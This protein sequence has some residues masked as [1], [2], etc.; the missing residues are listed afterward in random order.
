MCISDMFQISGG[1][2]PG[3]DHTRPGLPGWTN[4]HDAFKWCQRTN[5]LTA[6]VCDGCGSGSHSEVGAQIGA[7]ILTQYIAESSERLLVNDPDTAIP[8]SFWERI[9]MQTLS[10]FS[11]LAQAMG[12][13]LSSVVNDYFLFAFVGTLVT[14]KYTYVIACGDG[15]YALNGESHKLGPFPNNAPPYLMYNLT[16]SSLSEHFPE[17]LKIQIVETIPTEELN[18]LLIGTDGTS[19]LIEVSDR[20]VPG[21]DESVGLIDQFWTESKFFTNPD[22]IRRRLAL[23]NRET[24]EGGRI[25]SGLLRDDTTLVVVRRK[26]LL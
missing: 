11:V 2:V 17:L 14:S 23:I 20:P 21:K 22:I 3:T 16:G 5:S 15:I 8:E 25:K 19:D 26:Q 6:F 13:S 9:Q 1:S 12:P 10:H 24:V 7:Q 4:N 18:S